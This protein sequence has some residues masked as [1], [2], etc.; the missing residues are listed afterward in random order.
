MKSKIF[1]PIFLWIM[2]LTFQ[3][4]FSQEA[5]QDSVYFITTKDGNTISG[6]LHEKNEKQIS[7][8]TKNFGTV[9]VQR[10]SIKQLQVL[11]PTSYKNG[12][13]FFPNPNATRYFL[14]PSAI[15]LKKGEG[16]FQNTYVLFNSINYGIT[17]NISLGAGI[18]VITPFVK[19]IGGPFMLLTLKAGFKVAEKFHIAGTTI[20][21]HAPY[22]GEADYKN[23]STFLMEDAS[24]TYGSADYNITLGASYGLNGGELMNGP[25]FTL[26]AMA[27]V[28]PR[29]S[30]VTE[31]WMFPVTHYQYS[32][33]TSTDSVTGTSYKGF[34]SYGMRFMSQKIAVDLAFINNGDIIQNIAIGIP[35]VDFVVKF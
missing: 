26:S 29:F 3:K 28:T 8:T 6:T 1:F 11:P 33:L 23:E 25:S 22:L 10:D 16:Y 4:S 27:R 2:L 14:S 17:D 20:F 19:D 13:F 34:V 30:F 18:D 35:Y 31:N 24:F 12:K 5:K 32:Y 7:I 9:A 21:I 15:P